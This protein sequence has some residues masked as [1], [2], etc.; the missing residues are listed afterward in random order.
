MINVLIVED[1]I[2]YATNLMNLLNK[3]NN[4]IKVCGIAKNGFEALEILNQTNNIDV[5]LLDFKM[6]GYNG[7]QILEK[8]ID[9]KKYIKSC[10][11]ISGEIN[12]VSK[13]Y[14]NE[15]VHSVIYK[16]IDMNTIIKSINE[17]LEYKD[18]L[19]EA[20]IL[21]DKIIKEILY[22]GYDISHKGTQYLIKS[23]EYIISN[24]YI[25]LS[26]LEK[27]VYPKISTNSVHNVKSNIIRATNA[28]YC[29]CEVEKLKKYFQFDKDC[30]PKVKT[31]INTIVNK[32]M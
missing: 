14:K 8:I 25:D 10:I 6:P 12:S 23:L 21:K 9:K 30:K 16:T 7:D 15:L 28:M 32:L 24:P 3:C 5:I 22:L 1:N 29:E 26:N 19:K 11:I 13:F 31:V 4:N 20:S 27:E 18:S 17:L 2:Y